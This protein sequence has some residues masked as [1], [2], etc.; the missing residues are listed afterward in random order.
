MPRLVFAV[1]F[2]PLAVS[3][4]APPAAEEIMA[5]V[6]ANQDR[7]EAERTHFVYLQ[8]AR[9]S[10]RKGKTVRCAEIT[11]TR[12][13]PTDTGS[14]QQLLKLDGRLLARHRYIT[15]THLPEHHGQSSV[16]AHQ[17]DLNISIDTSGDGAMDR[18]LVEHLRNNLTNSR[19]KDG[20][21]A[22]LFPLTSKAQSVYSFHLIGRERLNG[23]DVF[24][25]AFDPNDKN[26][27]GWRGDAYID[28]TAFQPVLVRTTM[29]RKIPFAARSLLGTSLPG[30]G[31]TVIYAPQQEGL[32]FPISFGTEF[33][34]HVLFFLNREIN[35]SAEN[36]D[37]EKTHVTSTIV[38][39]P[40]P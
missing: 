9:V 35:L 33:K 22:G 1:L 12:V 23:R 5:R 29:A 38:P 39:I 4:Q 2:L 11:D 28:T 14:H 8:H 37:F 34:M 30:L 19:S 20:I 26:E 10:S 7:S 13:T 32:W 21:G 16:D 27:F 24:H 25:I 17:D 3:A 15:H 18:D 36:H 40:S 31:F 6:A